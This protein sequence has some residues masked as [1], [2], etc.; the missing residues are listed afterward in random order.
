MEYLDQM[1]ERARKAA[2]GMVKLGIDEKNQGLEAVAKALLT[3]G[4]AILGLRW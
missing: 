2:V 3:D 1:G 4:E